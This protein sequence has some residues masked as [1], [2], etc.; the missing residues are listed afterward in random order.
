MLKKQ[1]TAVIIGAG[2]AGLTTAYELVTR[3]K[4]KPVIIERTNRFGGLAT[5]ID[6]KGYKLDIG[7]HRFFTKSDRVMDWWLE[8]LPLETSKGNKVKIVYQNKA[9]ILVNKQLGAISKEPNDVM[10]VRRRKSRIYYNGKL[11]DYPLKLNLNTIR[12]LGI[13]ISIKI[14]FSYIQSVL[15][16]RKEN[17]LEDFFI[18][19][20]GEELYRI[21]F[22]T[23]TEK[24]WGKTCKEL[25]AEWGAQRIKGLSISKVIMASI[26]GKSRE[27]S[28][29]EKF[30]YPKYG[31]G[32]LWNKVAK[33]VIKEGGKVDFNTSVKSIQI[34]GNMV[35]NISVINR[36]GKEKSLS[37]DYFFSTMAISELVERLAPKPSKEIISI[38]QGLEYRD[39][40]VVGILLNKLRNKVDDNWI[41]IHD[42]SVKVGRIQIFNNWSPFLIKDPD[43]VWIGME[44]FCNFDVGFVSGT[45]CRNKTSNNLSCY[46]Y[47]LFYQEFRI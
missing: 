13:F 41:Y 1:K 18:N 38:A 10:L 8:K 37:G 28:L 44:Y 5:T 26:F 22:K 32:Q 36:N 11:F 6:Y 16:P 17:N 45:F 35:K 4:I 2:P 40:I 42:P 7:G 29:V 25:S 39:F 46:F 33:Q 9:K 21:F 3:S 47:L 43:K 23:Y 15:F 19:R 30:L 31:P 20:F 27:T 34:T 14:G 24:V 12:Q